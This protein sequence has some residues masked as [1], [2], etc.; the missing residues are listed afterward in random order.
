MYS[1]E[2]WKTD[3]MV[4]AER[5][6]DDAVEQAYRN[7]YAADDMLD[8]IAADDERRARE[9]AEKCREYAHRADVSPA[10]RTVV[11]KVDAGELTWHDIACGDAM[12]HP[13]VRAAVAADNESRVQREAVIPAGGTHRGRPDK[14]AYFDQFTVLRK[15]K[16]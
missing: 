7:M 10:W 4:R 14:D 16:R 5:E 15:R 8:E 13:A 9:W 1:N 3:E 6:L 2:D 12:D 11:Q